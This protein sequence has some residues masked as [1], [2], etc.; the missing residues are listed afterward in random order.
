VLARTDDAG[1]T[2]TDI[3]PP[4]QLVTAIRFV[5]ARVGWVAG[6]QTDGESAVLR[7]VEGG[8]TW[9]R[10]LVAPTAPGDYPPLQL[11]AIDSLVAWVLIP[12][13]HS[14]VAQIQRTVDGGRTWVAAG[15]TNVEAMRIVSATEAWIAIASSGTRRD[16][17]VTVDGGAEW[18]PSAHTDTG[19][20]VGLE[21]IGSTAW[22]LTRDGGYCTATTCERYDL[23]RT[24]DMGA[25]WQDL[26]NPKPTNTPCGG[27][28][29]LGPAFV[30]GSRGWLAENTGA[31]GVRASTGWLQSTDGG[32]TWK[33]S[34][35]PSQV[36]FLSVADSQHLWATSRNPDDPT[37][38]GLLASDDGAAT[39][40]GIDLTRL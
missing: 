37:H 28:H 7:T 33:C 30:S 20:V 3:S 4:L 24:T 8:A 23:T 5:D 25:S 2:W 12:T 16:I 22:V 40:Y 32:A 9:Q 29:L 18:T 35:T 1:A 38:S 14:C 17:Y 10:V 15:K 36:D 31:G 26:G 21:A 13:C 27:G 19:E 6:L 39:W 34:A 11:Q